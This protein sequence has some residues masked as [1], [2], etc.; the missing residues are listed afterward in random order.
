MAI[1][2]VEKFPNAISFITQGTVVNNPEVK[3]MAIDGKKPRDAD[4][5]YFQTFYYITK[6]EPAGAAKKFIDFTRSDAGVSIMKDKGIVPIL[7]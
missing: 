1:K 2:A 6:G 4:Y 3:T 7:D 5:P